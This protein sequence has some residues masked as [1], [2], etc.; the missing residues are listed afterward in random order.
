MERDRHN[1]DYLLRD[2]RRQPRRLVADERRER[3][4]TWAEWYALPMTAQQVAERWT[5]QTGQPCYG[6]KVRRV[7]QTMGVTMRSRGSRGNGETPV[8]RMVM[9]ES[10]VQRLMERIEKLEAA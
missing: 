5:R 7:L 4:K 10:V 1:R 2:A 3:N 9:L 6:E 8:R